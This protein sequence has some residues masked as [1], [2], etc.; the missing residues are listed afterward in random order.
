LR[1]QRIPEL[2]ERLER[3]EYVIDSRAVADAMVRRHA[4]RDEA[5]RLSR[6]LVS[7]QVDRPSALVEEPEAR[8]RP[9]AA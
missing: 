2:A 8:A 7:G 5:L 6:V 4:D 3:G 1:Q 9:D